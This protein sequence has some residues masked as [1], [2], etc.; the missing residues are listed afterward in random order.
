MKNSF[1]LEMKTRITKV[2]DVIIM[3]KMRDFIRYRKG[4]LAGAILF[5]SIGALYAGPAGAGSLTVGEVRGIHQ[6]ASVPVS[7]VV[8]DP[9]GEPI[10]GAN[11]VEKGTLNGTVTDFDGRFTLDVKNG[12]AILVVS[13][14][15]YTEQEVRVNN[16]RELRIQ[17]KE[18]NQLIEEVVVVGYGVQKKVN[19]TGSISTVGAKSIEARPVTNVS[20]SLAGLAS[21]VR[22]NQLSG[23]PGDDSANIRVRG[24]GTLN[25]RNSSALVI[26]DGIEG[27][28][29]AL[30]PS[31]IAEISI[32]KDAASSSIYGARAANGVILVTTKSGSVGKLRIS[33]SGTL[34][35]AQPT[36]VPEFVSDY[37]RYMELFNESMQN[38][39]QTGNF[40][41]TEID[42]WRDAAKN[43]KAIAK[44][45][46]PNYVAYPNTDWADALF[47]NNVVQQYNLSVTGGSETSKYVLSAGYLNNPGIIANTGTE[48]YQFCVNLESTFAKVLTLGTHTFMSIQDNQ[49]GQT[50]DQLFNYLSQKTPGLYAYKYDGYWAAPSSSAEDV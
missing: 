40:T 20:T 10:I 31:D 15:G 35:L 25:D 11:V 17:L 36:R 24:Q 34:S 16:Q 22:V 45:G 41:Q 46:Y 3:K 44:S 12:E 37:A 29:D 50:E 5:G 47:E 1:N 38:V 26:I 43:P 4:Y 49:M 32:L 33:F 21:G 23:R 28:L 48:R 19:M 18:D 9:S 13:Y 7:D 14:I 6:Q 30:N 2:S 8:T 27:T 42:L 39:G